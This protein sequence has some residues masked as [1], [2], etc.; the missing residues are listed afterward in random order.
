[1]TDLT[2]TEWVQNELYQEL[3]QMPLWTNA[4]FGTLKEGDILKPDDPRYR[5]IFYLVNNHIHKMPNH[6]CNS[7]ALHDWKLSDYIQT[8]KAALKS[9][10]QTSLQKTGTAS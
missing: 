9:I 4:A 10:N 5:L 1:M 2:T 6:L 8:V 3:L 7:D